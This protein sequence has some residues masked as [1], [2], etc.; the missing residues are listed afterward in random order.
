MKNLGRL[1]TV[2][3]ALVMVLSVLPGISSASETEGTAILKD[4]ATER[5]AETVEGGVTTTATF[6]KKANIL[7]IEEEGKEPIVIK[8]GEL[9]QQYL[10]EKVILAAPNGLTPEIGLTPENGLSPSPEIGLLAATTKQNTFINYEYTITHS[11]PEKWQLR[12]PKDDSI[13]NYYY[14]NVTR[15]SGNKTTLSNFQDR[16]EK[17][18]ALEWKFIGGSLTTAGLSWL[19]FILSVPTAGAGTLTAGLAALGA[20]GATA[21]AMIKIHGH[22]NKARTYY[23]SV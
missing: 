21:D 12:R 23:F 14:K 5:V 17:I 3:M 18:N 15:T 7:T 8:L 9:S 10:E 19:S 13:L 11:S 6:D 2:L 20:Y 1:V 16:V 22:A 4:N